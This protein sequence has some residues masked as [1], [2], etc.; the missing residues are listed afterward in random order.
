MILNILTRY[1]CIAYFIHSEQIN[2]AVFM[3][4]I[5][6]NILDPN[7]RTAPMT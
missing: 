1:V 3:Y 7:V 4:F 5:N 6:V 2:L